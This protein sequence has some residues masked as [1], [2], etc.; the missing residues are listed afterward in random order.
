MRMLK[1]RNAILLIGSALLLGGTLL[2]T[3]ADRAGI[4]FPDWM[5]VNAKHSNLEGRNYT[6]LPDLSVETA[7][8]ESFKMNSKAM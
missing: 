4:A 7:F 1:I 8:R 6:K 2:C 5:A 3:V